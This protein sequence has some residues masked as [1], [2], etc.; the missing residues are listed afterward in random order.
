[1]RVSTELFKWWIIDAFSVS[2]SSYEC[3]E[4]GGWGILNILNISINLL[5]DI[6]N[7][8][9]GKGRGAEDFKTHP[10]LLCNNNNKPHTYHKGQKNKSYIIP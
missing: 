10:I 7:I 5:N 3:G 2:H 9:N 6:L 4:L 8:W 1:M